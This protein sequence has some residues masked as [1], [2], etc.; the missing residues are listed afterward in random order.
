MLPQRLSVAEFSTLPQ[1]AL[2]RDQ[3]DRLLKFP[4]AISLS[5]SRGQDGAYDIS[6]QSYVGT[7][8]LGGLSLEIVPKLPIASVLFLI[9]YA[10]TGRRWDSPAA[11]Y[12][13]EGAFLDALVSLF[14]HAAHAVLRKG[15][16]QGYNPVVERT[17]Q[18]KGRLRICETIRRE[19]DNPLLL[20]V[21]HEDFSANIRENQLLR[22]AANKLL[23]I[24]AVH[25]ELRALLARVEQDLRDA[26]LLQIRG[27]HVPEILLTRLNRRYEYALG[28]A[29]M[30][31][32]GSSLE[33]FL[34]PITGQT[35]LVN[36]NDVFEDFVARVL[37]ERTGIAAGAMARK[38]TGHPLWLDDAR[39]LPL[40]PDL[41]WWRGSKCGGVADVKYKAF[42]AHRSD[43]YQMLAYMTA[44]GLDRGAIIYA[45]DRRQWS[46]HDVYATGQHILLIGFD[47]HGTPNEV[48]RE[49]D[50]VMNEFGAAAAWTTTAL[51]A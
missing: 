34:G 13:P 7:I 36:M 22:T 9:T 28:I 44:L 1:V 48:L 26:D 5:P 12:R 29:R 20:E 37:S 27:G 41:T 3:R 51:G 38:S 24:P 25:R 17:T 30:I 8:A 15:V 14:L 40:Y 33:L 4:Q 11:G 21:E 18:L 43:V 19:F 6:A 42:G 35:F 16:L 49:A 2:T 46:V 45:S 47:V 10:A 50:W 31:L 39:A 32:Q 23:A